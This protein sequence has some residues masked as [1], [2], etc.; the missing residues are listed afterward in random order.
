M[1]MRR[2]IGADAFHYRALMLEAYEAHPDAFISSAS[3]RAALPLHWW[4]ERLAVRADGTDAVWGA[5]DADRLVG[6]AGLSRES[7]EKV[8]HK[9]TLFGMYLIPQFRGRG[10]ADKLVEG[11][12]Q[13][14]RS[15]EGLT[16][17]QLTV[18]EGNRSARAL[19]ERHGFMAFGVE[20][21]AVRVAE[22]YVSKVH[23]WCRL[24]VLL[25]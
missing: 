23:M 6:V 17:V 3:E 22:G 7:R 18:T 1:S 24:K 13:H 8:A 12:L 9:A 21:Y 5:F 25:S 16:L 14:A 10:I 2:L 15:R 4:E 19:Y 20:P 11:V